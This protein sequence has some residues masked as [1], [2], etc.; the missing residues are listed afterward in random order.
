MVF[1]DGD[2]L[3][4]RGTFDEDEDEVAVSLGEDEDDVKAF[5][6]DGGVVHPSAPR[7]QEDVRDSRRRDDAHD[8]RR[9]EEFDDLQRR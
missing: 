8:A 7:R 9:Q 5:L 2:D 3:S 6:G 1:D 4:R